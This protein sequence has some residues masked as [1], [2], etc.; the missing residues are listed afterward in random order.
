MVAHLPYT[1]SSSVSTFL[2]LTAH[3]LLILFTIFP[4]YFFFH[5]SLLF[6]LSIGSF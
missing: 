3:T 6:Q 1:I 5:H 4:G 2:Y